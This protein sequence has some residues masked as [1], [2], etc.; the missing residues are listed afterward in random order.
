MLHEKQDSVASALSSDSSN[1]EEGRSI[2]SET[3]KQV[4]MMTSGLDENNLP[5]NE[6]HIA[7]VLSQRRQITGF[8]HEDRKREFERFKHESWDK[9][10]FFAMSVIVWFA[11]F[12][13]SLIFFKEQ[14]IT[15]LAST[16]TFL[17]GYGLGSK[18]KSKE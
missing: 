9:K 5:F 1:S 7:E 6:E 15:I 11:V 2:S 16:A 4:M 8:I 14:V 13:I 10:F 17:G 18:S 3:L 12:I